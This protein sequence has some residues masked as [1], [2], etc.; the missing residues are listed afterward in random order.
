M[1]RYSVDLRKKVI[2]AYKLGKG[3]I[4]QLADQFMISPATIYSYLKKDRENQD[5][6]PK[7][8][9]PNRPGK[10]ESYRDFIIQM[11]QDHPDWTVRQYREHFLESVYKGI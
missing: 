8:P 3:S 7:K 10:L 5:L 4:R 11:V 9:G 1:S 6:T 2:N